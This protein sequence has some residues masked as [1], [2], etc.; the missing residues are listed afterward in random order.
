MLQ[1][2]LTLDPRGLAVVVSEKSD[3]EMMLEGRS[4]WAPLGEGKTTP[5]KVT[6]EERG[7]TPPTHVRIK[8]MILVLLNIPSFSH[9]T[10][11]PAA[12]K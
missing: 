8:H 2:R 1:Q 6:R 3:T 5:C 11:K 4:A 12:R 9:V 7:F 10:L